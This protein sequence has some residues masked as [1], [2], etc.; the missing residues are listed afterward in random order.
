VVAGDDEKIQDLINF[1]TECALGKSEKLLVYGTNFDRTVRE[2]EKYIEEDTHELVDISQ[3]TVRMK[4]QKLLPT[5]EEGKPAPEIDELDDEVFKQVDIVPVRDAGGK[6]LKGQQ[7]VYK[8]KQIVSD[9]FP[10]L[11]CDT[12]HASARCTEYKPG[13]ACAYHKLFKRF[14][15]RNMTDLIEAMQGMV[16]LNLERMQRVA[17]FELLGTGLPDPT[18]SGMIDQNMRLVNALKQLYE[19]GS[20]EVLRHT[21]VV[22]ADGSTEE[23]TSVRNPQSG[24]ILEKLFMSK[25][26]EPVRENEGDLVEV[27][28]VKV[29]DRYKEIEDEEN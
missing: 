25:S 1:Y 5:P 9:K 7:Q 28:A 2:R 8:P 13:H 15:T 22:R 18:L 24:G 12:C 6:F 21:K 3:E 23:S 29:A 16:G 19:S 10:K 14:D 27:Q 20:E 17:L 11:A 26:S 4:L